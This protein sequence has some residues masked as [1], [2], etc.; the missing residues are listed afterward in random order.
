MMEGP[1]QEMNARMTA[2]E[3]AAK[4]ALSLFKNEKESEHDFGM[5]G[6]A[7]G[8]INV[9]RIHRVTKQLEEALTGKHECDLCEVLSRPFR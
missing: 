8:V 7:L 3:D 6:D 2:L 9:V 5:Y 4:Q 1:L